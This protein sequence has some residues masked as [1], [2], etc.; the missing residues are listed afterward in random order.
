MGAPFTKV[1]VTL[2]TPLWGAAV[3]F[4]M[5]VITW[6]SVLLMRDS[7]HQAGTIVTGLLLSTLIIW[8]HE[9]ILH[10]LLENF[11]VVDLV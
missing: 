10:V 1:W 4:K 9:D 3:T 11:D 7:I 5:Y 6:H 8:K 2:F